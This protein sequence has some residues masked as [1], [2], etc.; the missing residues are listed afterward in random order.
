MLWGRLWFR[1]LLLLP[2]LA[3][4]ASW[5]RWSWATEILQPP[6][7]LKEVHGCYSSC[8]VEDG[9]GHMRIS[10]GTDPLHSFNL[11]TNCTGGLECLVSR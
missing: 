4:Q 8:A 11:P 9:N 3:P 1:D 2:T 6:F 7:F 5:L 10:L